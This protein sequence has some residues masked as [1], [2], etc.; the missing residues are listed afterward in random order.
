M[1]VWIWLGAVAVFGI[2][3]AVTAALVSIWFVAG[4]VVALF[5]A[6]AGASMLVQIVLFVI[7]SGI[8]LAAVR[9]VARRISRSKITPTN[10]D[11]LVGQKARVTQAVD[12][13]QSTGF[14]YAGGKIWSARSNRGVVI[15]ENE[16]VTVIGIEGV[17]LIVE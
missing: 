4:A 13:D 17:K 2:L 1:M 16:L 9:P 3:E 15:P 12:N 11:R 14:V 7:V 5:A 8:T 10:A 6:M